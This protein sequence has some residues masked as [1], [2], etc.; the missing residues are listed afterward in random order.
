MATV[1]VGTDVD[2]PKVVKA[3]NDLV[4]ALKAIAAKLDGDSGVNDTDFRSA[5]TNALDSHE[6]PFD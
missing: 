5:I 1:N 6:S 3:L 2:M 4:A